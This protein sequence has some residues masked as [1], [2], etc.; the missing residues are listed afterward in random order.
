MFFK[1]VRRDDSGIFDIVRADS[2]EQAY[3]QA[4]SDCPHLVCW[5][6]E[7][8]SAEWHRWRTTD[9]KQIDRIEADMVSADR[10]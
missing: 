7:A 6:E 9:W 1:I 10:F 3:L 8:T 5:V 4:I 2:R